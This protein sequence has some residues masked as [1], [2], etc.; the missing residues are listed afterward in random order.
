M[1]TNL[2]G[3]GL[4]RTRLEGSIPTELGRLSWLEQ[5]YLNSNKLDGTIP[6]ELGLLTNSDDI[7]L[8]ESFLSG[9]VP[10]KDWTSHQTNDSVPQ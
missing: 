4:F 8:H 1:A 5:I 9:N 10:T 7:E 3:L 6:S 2:R